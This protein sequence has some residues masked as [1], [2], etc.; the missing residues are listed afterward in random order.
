LL[1]FLSEHIYLEL[2]EFSDKANWPESI[3][4][5]DYPMPQEDLIRPRLEEAVDRMQQLILLGRQKRTE[6]KIKV[7]TPLARLTVIHKDQDLLDE[8]S[9]L[10][11]YI[12]SELNVKKVEYDTQEDKYIN[13]YAKPNLPVLGKRLGKRMGQYMKL[14][15]AVTTEQLKELEDKGGLTLQDET[16]SPEDFLIFREAKEGTKA[17]SNRFIS[18]DLDCNL[19]DELIDEGLARE[20]INRIQRTRKE[21]DFNVEDR[22]QITFNSNSERLK[23]AILKHKDYI[24]GETLA[25]SLTEKAE[26]K[27]AQSFSIDDHDLELTISKS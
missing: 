9:K 10:E 26:K 22:I 27:N 24:C 14:I 19:T 3:H 4:L 17:V 6:E 23:N 2:L 8:I 16:F 7:K 15:K 25:V 20:C 12:K 11:V 21:L 5:C 18:I 13:L 1:L